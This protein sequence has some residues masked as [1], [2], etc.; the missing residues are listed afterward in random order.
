MAASN[1]KGRP[2]K[3][4]GP[5][6]PTRTSR[7]TAPGTRS[8]SVSGTGRSSS[9]GAARAASDAALNLPPADRLVEAVLSHFAD[10]SPPEADDRQHLAEIWADGFLAQSAGDDAPMLVAMS[11]PL[12]AT[13]GT[14]H[15]A[16]AD[17][18]LAGLARSGP[19]LGFTAFAQAWDLRRQEDDVDPRALALGRDT[20][21]GAIEIAHATGDGVTLVVELDNPTGRFTVGVYVDHNLGGLATDVL[22]GPTLD[23]VREMHADPD[24]HFTVTDVAIEDVAER[25]DAALQLTD[26]VA[27]APV[28]DDFALHL[29]FVIRRMAQLPTLDLFER[30]RRPLELPELADQDREAIVDAFVHGPEH[31]ALSAAEQA[32]A[33]VLARSFIDHAVDATVGSPLRVSP[34]LVALYC[35]RWYPTNGPTDPEVRAH[36]PAVLAAWLHHAATTTGLPPQWLDE[37]L[38]ILTEHA[39]ALTAP[40][41]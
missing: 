4:K 19:D 27:D 20:A 30:T 26:L 5:G 36:A 37:S 34:M 9:G 41:A 32:A 17:L 10:V 15:T 7:V 40:A 33:P 11:T 29:P 1:R 6:G 24:D 21:L 31:A 16:E 18:V 14:L 12:A 38:A 8:E 39:D 28:S 2:S 25:F 35:L 22:V 3:R 13:L 23:E